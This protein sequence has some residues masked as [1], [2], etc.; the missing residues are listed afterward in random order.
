MAAIAV[1]PRAA[2]PS[3][4]QPATAAP[5]EL[6]FAAR[7]MEDCGAALRCALCNIGDRLG[8]LKAMADSGPVTAAELAR[9]TNLNA[10]LLR[11][12]LNAMAAA[13]YL[14]Y[15]PADRT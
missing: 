3:P 15:R 10:R 14:E 7:V 11:E 1:L 12:W 5:D 9:R 13:S 8:L 6:Q 2:K 4:Q